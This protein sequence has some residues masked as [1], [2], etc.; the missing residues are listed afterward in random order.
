MHPTDFTY[1]NF[2]Y[3]QIIAKIPEDATSPDLRLS[4]YQQN[5][6]IILEL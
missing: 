4:R 1:S 6:W 3:D 2:P 5:K